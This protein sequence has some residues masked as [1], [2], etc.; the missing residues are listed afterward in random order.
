MIK[1]TNSNELKTNSYSNELIRSLREKGGKDTHFE[2]NASL[3]S[4]KTNFP[5]LDYYLGYNVN[6]YDENDHIISRYPSLGITAGCYVTFIGKPSTSKTTTA[7]Q[8][9]ANIVR[10]FPNGSVIHYDLEQAMNYTRIQKLTKFKMSDIRD[11]KYI[12]RQEKNSISDI[13][14][15]IADL[16][17]EKTSNPDVYKYNSGKLN[18]FGEEIVL[19]EPTVVIIDSIA[20]LSTQINENDKKELK[21]LEE[22]SSQTDKMRLAAEISRFYT[23]L[24]PYI[25]TAN[26]I[27]ISIN[28]IKTKATVGIMPSASEIL[29]LKQDESLP[30][31]KAPQFY[32]HILIKFV[33]VG[34]QK[35]TID[36][37]GID[38]FGVRLEIIKSRVSQAGQFLN[39]VYDKNAGIDS[40]R[41]SI[42]YAK[43][44]GLTGGNRNAFYF[45]SHKDQKFSLKDVHNAFKERR[46][47][48]KVLYSNIIPEL[49][50]RLVTIDESDLDIIEEESDYSY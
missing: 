14:K 13:K 38:G 24:L 40:L 31:G 37:D 5:Q 41:S 42:F 8:I 1:S 10:S 47:L 6:V 20:T 9:A 39:L 21:K 28:Q 45:T 22:V 35:Y 27:V 33:A 17:L 36:E 29:Y 44:L 3:V 11:G 2:C 48:Y 32:S 26:I 16:Y 50:K 46:E 49:E 34:S 4:Y 7:S 25:R 43:D 23:E 30:G 18:E 15:D 12:L 19:Y